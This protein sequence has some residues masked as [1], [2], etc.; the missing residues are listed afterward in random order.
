MFNQVHS[1][2]R[3]T[4]IAAL[5][6]LGHGLGAARARWQA[7][8]DHRRAMALLLGADQALLADIG[9]DRA[10]VLGHYL[11][12]DLALRPDQERRPRG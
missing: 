10:T 1:I 6:R 5:R 4:I 3:P 2:A 7:R 11:D 9:L 8:R 12:P